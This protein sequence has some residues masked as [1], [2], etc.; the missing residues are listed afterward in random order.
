MGGYVLSYDA[1]ITTQVASYTE[2]PGRED[3]GQSS[4]TLFNKP[5]LLNPDTYWIKWQ[6]KRVV[7][8][9]CRHRPAWARPIIRWLL[10]RESAAYQRLSC[11]RFLPKWLGWVDDDAFAVQ[12]VDALPI[13]SIDEDV[14]LSAYNNLRKAIDT[15]NRHLFFHLD[16]RSSGNILVTGTGQIYVIDL[17]STLHLRLWSAPLAPL[18]RAWDCYG[19][20]KWQPRK[21]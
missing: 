1:K 19:L 4:R 16:L 18:F 2:Y 13:S 15:L 7:V 11:A 3:L 14:R 5:S 8:K 12:Y 6:G 20:S 10:R 9:D 17:A 21:H